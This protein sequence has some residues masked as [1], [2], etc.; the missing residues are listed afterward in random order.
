MQ[1]S[2]CRPS[3][4]GADQAEPAAMSRP[5]ANMR[6]SPTAATTAIA[7]TG[8][9][10]ETVAAPR[11]GGNCSARAVRSRVASGNL[12]V[13]R[14]PS[15]PEAMEYQ[16][17]QGDGRCSASTKSRGQP[18]DECRAANHDRRSMLEQ[19]CTH[20]I[21][22]RH[23]LDDEPPAHPV[24]RYADPDDLRPMPQQAEA[25]QPIDGPSTDFGS[26]R[27]RVTC[28]ATPSCAPSAPGSFRAA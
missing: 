4:A 24:Q 8:P 16:D 13:E 26:S 15:L 5:R 7:I 21:D 2:A 12:D 14:E 1:A 6:P 27:R 28:D 10:P 22:H 25:L 18:V 11:R 17:E 19:R 23:A 9:M 20:L 3:N